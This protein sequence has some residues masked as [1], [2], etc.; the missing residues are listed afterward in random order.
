MP[1]R[2]ICKYLPAIPQKTALM[3]G[4]IKAVFFIY[5]LYSSAV[6]SVIIIPPMQRIIYAEK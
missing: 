1:Y 6:R 5:K 4:D 2:K 3:S